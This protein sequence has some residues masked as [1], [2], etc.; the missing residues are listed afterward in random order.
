MGIPVIE[1]SLEI[2]TL[3]QWTSAFA[4]FL[5]V[6]VALFKDEILRWWRKPRLTVSITLAPPDCHKTTLNY[7]VQKA[8]ITYSSTDCY[9]LRVWVSNIG[10][11]RA[12]KVQVFASKLSRRSA[13]GSFKVVEAFLPMNL[14]WAHGQQAGGTPEIFAEG[15]SPMMG[16]HCDLGHVVDPEFRKDIGEDLAEVP[17]DQTI[18]S[19]DL[20]IKPNTRSHLISPGVYRLEL[21]VAAANSAPVTKVIELTITGKWFEEQTKMFTDGLGLIAI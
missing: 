17:A 6:M 13:D 10:K 19:L 11:T 2:G 5:A 21:R 15:I 1:P 4:T 20:E 9:Y 14:R 18:L 3:A 7:A 16:K 12:E 8:A